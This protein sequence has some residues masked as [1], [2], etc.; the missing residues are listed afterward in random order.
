VAPPGAP[1]AG[2]NTRGHDM[3]SDELK[4]AIKAAFARDPLPLVNALGLRIDE[5]RSKPPSK[6][7]CY[8]G[9]ESE[10][11]LLIG[12]RAGTEGIWTRFGGN[13]DNSVGDCFGLVQRERHTTFPEALGIV[14]SVYGIAVP[15]PASKQGKRTAKTRE[16]IYQVR[17]ANGEVL[18]LHHRVEDAET[19]K[20]RSVWWTTPDGARGLG[21]LTP[22]GLPLYG[23]PE[24][25]AQPPGTAVVVCEGEKAADAVT[26]A[27]LLAVGTY[28]TGAMPDDNALRPLLDR[29]VIL[30]PDADDAGRTHMDAIALRLQ[31]LGSEAV[32]LLDWPDAPEKGDAADCEPEQI[33]SLV[34]GAVP[35][36]PEVQAHM[37][38]TPAD[39]LAG[40][41]S[42]V[43]W[44]WPDWLPLGFITILAAAAGD[45]KSGI[46]LD[47]ARRVILGLEWPN[48]D[49]GNDVVRPGAGPVL[50][51]DC[52]GCQA[53]WVSRIKAWGVPEEAVWFPGD[54][55]TR[56]ALD[57]LEALA[58]VRGTVEKHAAKLLIIDSLR[59]GLPAGVDE[60]DS[61]IGAILAPWADLARDCGLAILI[62]HHYG[63]QK[64]GEGGA[65]TLDRLRGSTAIGAAARSVI[66]IDRPQEETR[67]EDGRM[68]LSVVKSNLGP[69][70][71][72]LGFAIGADG[73]EWCAAPEP[74]QDKN[75]PARGKAREFLEAVLQTKPMCFTDLKALAEEDRISKNSLYAA[76]RLLR[77]VEVPDT[78]D[79]AGRRKLWSLPAPPHR[80]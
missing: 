47:L 71:Q 21:G 13:G 79:P 52:E 66:A 37:L 43:S 54:G 28:G 11:S 5:R 56:V 68:R 70:P 2:L 36:E 26:A 57:D 42:E 53:I 48:T 38:W 8:D 75:A 10:A 80:G 24:L 67:E 61:S 17:N 76:K 18:A 59:S 23:L 45:G 58:G 62:V 64:R 19:G 30:W 49:D 31:A 60:N 32:L 65:A 20:K 50:V 34:N 12:G 73:V 74:K 15:P 41:V 6:L 51:L 14:A 35:W 3:A 7:W 9:T 69:F 40:R 29:I 78:T 25:L 44:L 77:I 39:I 27:G 16:I 1:T 46:A 72:P 22:S 55:F 63:K 33:A 4:A